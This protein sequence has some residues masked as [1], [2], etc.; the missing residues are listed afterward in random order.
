MAEKHLYFCNILVSRW[1]NALGS[2]GARLQPKL[3]LKSILV[4]KWDEI[5]DMA[6]AVHVFGTLKSAYPD[7]KL[8]V[9]CK[10]FVA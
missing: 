6:A 4:V 10:P 8:T 7:A 1:V 2:Q 9:L 5:G 3:S